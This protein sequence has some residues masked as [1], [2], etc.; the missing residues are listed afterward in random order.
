MNNQ[1]A[2][3]MGD[4]LTNAQKKHQLL[5]QIHFDRINVDG[6]SVDVL[7]D[8]VWPAIVRMS[9]VDQAS[10][11]RMIEEGKELTLFEETLA[12]VGPLA[13]CAQEF[14]SNLGLDLTVYA[15]GQINGSHPTCA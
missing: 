1:M 11:G 7:H 13:V 10:D 15:L 9:G 8:K 2:M 6:N 5:A 4:A 12:P 3:R 14:D